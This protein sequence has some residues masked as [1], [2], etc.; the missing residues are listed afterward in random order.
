MTEKDKTL[1][2]GVDEM[3]TQAPEV[4]LC[5]MPFKILRDEIERLISERDALAASQE[6]ISV[7]D[8]LPKPETDVMV[9]F[10]DG[11]VWCLWQNWRT[12][13]EEDPLLYFIDFPTKTHHVTHWKP[14]PKAPEV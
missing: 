6:W 12:S 3:I 13:E 14:M 9:S 7:D 4:G 10:D 2:A 8:R 5:A 11:E 1:L